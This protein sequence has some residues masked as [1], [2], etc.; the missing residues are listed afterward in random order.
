M[1][2]KWNIQSMNLILT[3]WML[4]K[5]WAMFKLN[6]V[7]SPKYKTSS[8][9][10]F[11]HCYTPSLVVCL[12]SNKH[13]LECCMHGPKLKQEQK[14]HVR[15]WDSTLILIGGVFVLVWLPKS[16][17]KVQVSIWSHFKLTGKK[18]PSVPTEISLGP[19]IP[20]FWTFSWFQSCSVPPQTL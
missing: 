6:T 15:D 5:A 13:P 10:M 20:H 14:I 12:T 19:P 11:M 18:T 7:W 2:I 3:A 4:E 16:I 17:G 8:T 9:S 1:S